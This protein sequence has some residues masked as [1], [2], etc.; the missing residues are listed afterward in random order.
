MWF[1]KVHNPSQLSFFICFIAA[2]GWQWRLVAG[3]VGGRANIWCLVPLA[4]LN[5][6]IGKT[7]RL[8]AQQNASHPTSSCRRC[9]D[10]SLQRKKQEGKIIWGNGHSLTKLKTIF[11]T[12]VSRFCDICSYSRNGGQ[13]SWTRHVMGAILAGLFLFL[14]QV[15]IV[16]C[17]RIFCSE[18]EYWA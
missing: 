12:A 4:S 6:P 10:G 18:C 13:P 1:R 11:L 5:A 3:E 14:D 9:N 7:W 8:S 2:A 16:Y 15:S 17:R